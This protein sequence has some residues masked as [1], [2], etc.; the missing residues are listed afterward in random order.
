MARQYLVRARELESISIIAKW[1]LITRI[2]SCSWYALYFVW[3]S[4][5]GL[6]GFSGSVSGIQWELSP[7]RCWSL[8][9][10]SIATRWNIS[11]GLWNEYDEYV[12]TCVRMG[13]LS[14]R[15]FANVQS[16]SAHMNGHSGFLHATKDQNHPG[17]IVWFTIPAADSPC[18]WCLFHRPIGGLWKEK[19]QCNPLWPHNNVYTASSSS[20]SS[21]SSK[22]L[23]YI[24][25]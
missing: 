14:W 7:L 19:Q 17:T 11:V 8:W 24:I 23:Y 15:C 13:R 21:S 3:V 1:C 20:S 6:L 22:S 25:R 16:S 4:F 18:A 12:S 2:I 9:T 5:L 10:T